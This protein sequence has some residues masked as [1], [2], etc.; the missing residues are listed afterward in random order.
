MYSYSSAVYQTRQERDLGR[1]LIGDA[2]N[3][4]YDFVLKR[5]SLEKAWIGVVPVTEP[6]KPATPYTN[7]A[8]MMGLGF[9]V[10]NLDGR[11]YVFHDGDQGGFSSEMF[12]DPARRLASILAVNTTDTGLPSK[13]LHA[14]SNTEPEPGADLR[15][16][17]RGELI[18]RVFP[19]YAGD[20][21]GP[22][23]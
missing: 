9:F 2:I 21:G 3:P 23:K 15:L 20:K 7:G 1:F 5:S 11:R 6:G 22:G 12:I 19:A 18:D 8:P 16:A 13:T 10:M 14:Q 17:L 4:R